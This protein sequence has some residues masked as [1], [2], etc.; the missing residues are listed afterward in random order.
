MLERRKDRLEGEKLGRDSWDWWEFEGQFGNLENW[1]LLK[2]YDGSP[3][4]VS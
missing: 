1:K 3:N 2:I 4:E